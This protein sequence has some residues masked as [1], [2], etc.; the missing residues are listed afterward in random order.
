M[1]YEVIYADKPCRSVISI[2]TRIET[3]LGFPGEPR[4]KKVE[5]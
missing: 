1:A 5:V 4:F 2:K 3:L